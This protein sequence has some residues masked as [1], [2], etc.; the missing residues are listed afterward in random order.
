MSD[1]FWLSDDLSSLVAMA[2]LASR[3]KTSNRHH[4]MSQDIRCPPALVVF[5]ATGNEVFLMQALADRSIPSAR[6]NLSGWDSI[7]P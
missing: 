3:I 2:H 5:E 4:E 7:F 6:V 1:L